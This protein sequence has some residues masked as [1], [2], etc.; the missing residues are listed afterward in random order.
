MKKIDGSHYDVK[1]TRQEYDM[2]RLWIEI[3]RG[4]HGHVRGVQPP[5]ERG[6]DAF[7]R[8]E[9]RAGKTSWPDRRTTLPDVPRLGRQLGTTGQMPA[10]GVTNGPTAS[11]PNVL[12]YPA[13]L[14]EPL[15]P[16]VVPRSR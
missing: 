7:G 3:G 11:R 5:G 9:A 6:R 16:V 1:L 4:F 10:I 2:V 12:N 14:L 8:L 15:Q 13:V